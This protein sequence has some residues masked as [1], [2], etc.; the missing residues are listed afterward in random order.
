MEC[1]G[2]RARMSRVRKIAVADYVCC[3]CVCAPVS[4]ELAVNRK[5][6]AFMIFGLFVFGPVLLPL[7]AFSRFLLVLKVDM[8][9]PRPH[10]HVWDAT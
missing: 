8:R 3:C 6:V 4:S 7:A 9:G 2:A 5:E 1:R 10:S